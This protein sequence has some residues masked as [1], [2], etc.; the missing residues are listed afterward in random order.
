MRNH[1]W[2][3]C[4]LSLTALACGETTHGPDDQTDPWPED[5]MTQGA[6]FSTDKDYR[7]RV[8]ERSI[9][10][11]DNGYSTLRLAHYGTSSG[12]DE[13]P[14]WNPR[15]R[16]I[17]VDDIGRFAQAPR[18]Y[19]TGQFEEAFD[20]LEA[21][22]HDALMALGKDAFER[23]PLQT[24]MASGLAIDSNQSVE[25]SGIWRDNR[26]RLGGLVRVRINDKEEVFSKTCATCHA[27]PNEDGML[28]H[29][30]SHADFNLGLLINRYWPQWT[31][32]RSWGPGS[33][34]VTNDAQNNP[35]AIIDLRPIRHQKRLHWAATLHNSL[36]ALAVR[37]DTLI[38]TSL[39]KTKRP[40]REVSFAI[41]YY[42]WQ[43][44]KRPETMRPLTEKETRGQSHFTTHCSSCHNQ[45]GTTG[46]PIALG[47]IGTDPAVGES[48]N[49]GTG[50]YRVPSLWKVADRTQFFHHGK[51]RSL[52]TLLAPNRSET[53]EGHPFGLSLDDKARAELIAFLQTIG[54]R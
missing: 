2:I 31:E 37:V 14:V 41:A 51:I 1:I 11:P 17:T 5:A 24:D 12:W 49:R 20:G 23:F 30:R 21:W 44:G 46:E 8:L 34:D 26:G 10:N 28:I 53:V 50:T 32:A 19:N 42:L 7:R 33:V 29:G 36:P 4:L 48:I 27:S 18:R 39:G 54:N 40:P 22:S 35:A 43:M 45:D 9:V 15:V 13:L 38:I 25:Q 16:P 6:R 52:E 3:I 47:I